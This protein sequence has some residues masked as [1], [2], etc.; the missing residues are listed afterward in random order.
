MSNA[1]ELTDAIA[2]GEDLL[3]TVVVVFVIMGKEEEVDSLFS[4]DH[5]LE[6]SPVPGAW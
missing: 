2:P 6:K 1:P 5:V 4:A 3:E